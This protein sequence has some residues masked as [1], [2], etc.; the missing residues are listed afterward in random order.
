MLRAAAI[1][2][3][4]ALCTSTRAAEISVFAASSLTDVLK[5][6][7]ETYHG[8]SRDRVSFNFAASNT[9]A[10]QIEEGAP[11]DVFFSADQ[12]QIERLMENGHLIR[13]TLR[14][15]LSNS[16]V[17]IA[18]ADSGLKINTPAEL[19]ALVSRV[20]LAD[21]KI[22]PVGIYARTYL[23]R[24]GVW[25][26]LAPKVIPVENVRAALAAVESGNVDAGFVYATDARVSQ[27]VKIIF[28]VPAD[29]E[30]RISYPA[31]VVTG[32]RNRETAEKFL[33]F[34]QSET[35]T[36]IFE[37]HGFIVPGPN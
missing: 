18:P 27:K 37:S 29:E 5:Q 32:T 25:D 8:Q 14:P 21:P 33:E 30:P 15:L 16:L 9:L 2:L 31:A 12:L 26:A 34:L 3:A 13:E 22:V 10:R 23:T 4:L 28:A 1:A 36:K 24:L 11:A 17:V 7:A 20:A 35:A 19:A 6:I